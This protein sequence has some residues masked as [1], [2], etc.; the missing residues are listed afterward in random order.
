MVKYYYVIISR[1][2]RVLCNILSK[3]AIRQIA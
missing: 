3:R 1:K 2:A